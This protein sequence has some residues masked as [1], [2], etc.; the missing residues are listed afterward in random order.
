MTPLLEVNGLAID[1]KEGGC[2]NPL[3]TD[4]S[5]VI[6]RGETVGLVGESG[7]GKSLT[8]RAL[9]SLLQP[10]L[11]AQGSI[12]FDGVELV[13]NDGRVSAQVRGRDIGLLMQDPFTMLNPVRT[14]G[15]HI[16]ETLRVSKVGAGLRG[17][18]MRA[19]VARRLAEVGIDRPSVAHR[20]P[21][22]LSG[23]MLQRVALACVLAS[24]PR[25]LVADEPTTALDATTQREILA[26]L[27][28]IQQD[29]GMSLLLITHDLRLAFASCARVLVMYAGTLVEASP[30]ELVRTTPAHPYTRGLLEAVPATDHYQETLVGIPGRVPPVSEVLDRCGFASRCQYVTEGC[31]TARPELRL[32]TSSQWSACVRYGELRD[33]LQRTAEAASSVRRVV[34]NRLPLMSISELS[35]DYG[36]GAAKHA[37]L[38]GVDLVLS[39]GEALGVVGESGSGK[40]TLA[41]SVLGLTTPTAGRIMLDGLDVSD[42]RRLDNADV[43]RARRIVQCVFQDPYSSLNPMHSVGY[44]LAEALS[45]R[46]P[47]LSRAEVQRE[48]RELLELV[49]LPATYASRRPAALSGGQRQRV[50]VARALA[51]Q[52]QVLVC[53]EP[54]AALDVSIQAQILGLLREVNEQGTALLFITHDLGVVRQV[55]SRVVVLYRGSIVEQG[56]TD[57][58]LNAP[59]HDYTRRLVASMPRSD[60]TWQPTGAHGLDVDST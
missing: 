30:A 45:F 7:S 21:F 25:L 42:Y 33:E 15:H 41:R 6:G 29:R 3:V 36:S 43:A 2:S 22:E 32:V 58:V 50:A 12:K 31:K 53:D 9:V 5:F 38:A 16:V 1:H 44:T 60:G 55:T 24:N 40:T 27:A 23:G 48:I 35:K 57:E 8:A 59:Q 11:L 20:Y 19:E 51:V 37:A 10:G 13:G 52:P 18:E 49:G 56:A 28:R 14:V 26:L 17:K 46:V 34:E 47:H 54:V 39:S 4:V